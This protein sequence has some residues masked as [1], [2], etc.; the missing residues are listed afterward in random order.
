M[1]G[2]VVGTHPVIDRDMAERM[3]DS[4]TWGLMDPYEAQATFL[5]TGAVEMVTRGLVY[6]LEVAA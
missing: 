4:M 6:R 2:R 3:V 1:D 5:A